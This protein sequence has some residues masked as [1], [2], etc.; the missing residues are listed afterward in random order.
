VR[1]ALPA[2]VTVTRARHPLQGRELR[3]LGWMRR[4]GRLELM[5]E[6][7]DGSKR[8]IP[9]KH[10]SQHGG[11]DDEAAGEPGTLGRT[12][13]LLGLSGLVSRSFRT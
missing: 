4:H 10:T 6:L 2:A 1:P 12:T 8:L 3:V 11:A 7:P 9:A 5:L 13:D